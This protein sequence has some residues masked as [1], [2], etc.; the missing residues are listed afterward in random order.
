VEKGKNGGDYHNF[1]LYNSSPPCANL[2]KMAQLG[3]R[4]EFASSEEEGGRGLEWLEWT[5]T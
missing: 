3:V 1:A 5:R 2:R 4:G